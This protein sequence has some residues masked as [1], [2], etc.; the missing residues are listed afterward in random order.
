MPASFDSEGSRRE[1]LRTTVGGF[2]GAALMPAVA[3]SAQTAGASGQMLKRKFGR[4]PDLVSLLGLGGYHVGVGELSDAESVRLIQSAI[5]EGVTFLDNAWCYHD[6]RSET[7]VGLALQGRRDRVFVMT[8]HHG[9]EKAVALT[10]L[11][12][13]L[14]R[15]KTDH[16][17]LWMFHECVYDQD[18][19]RIF[20]PGGGIEAA[21]L[22]RQ[23]GKVRYIGFTGHKSP[24][25][26]LKM[27]AYDFPWDAVLMPLNILDGSFQSFEKWVLP[28]LVKRGIAALAMKTRASGEIVRAGLATPEECWRY[29]A[30]LPVATIVSGIE[31]ADLLRKNLDL[32][33]GLSPMTPEEKLAILG[34]TREAALA[35]RHERF[36]TSTAFDSPVG[37][38]LYGV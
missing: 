33:R 28:V 4:H 32:A 29:V 36:K 23:Q 18:P 19:D 37:R 14:R 24:Q 25:V 34:R 16:L 7:R 30:A 27:L 10:H 20:A 22:A 8:K 2:V 3:R 9:R 21:V 6:G 38:R 31:S 5:D 1:F 11:E 15:L 13:S 17:D 26:H 35:G 12:D